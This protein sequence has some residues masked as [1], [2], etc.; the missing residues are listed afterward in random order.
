MSIIKLKHFLN[1]GT[2]EIQLIAT[3]NPPTALS[4]GYSAPFG[5]HH[6]SS[7][8]NSVGNLSGPEH[9]LSKSGSLR[10]QLQHSIHFAVLWKYCQRPLPATTSPLENRCLECHQ[11]G[12]R[13]P[14]VFSAVLITQKGDCSRFGR[15]LESLST[16]IQGGQSSL[17]QESQ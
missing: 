14:S 8:E 12:R 11:S 6:P 17:V 13:S 7:I 5:S 1:N 3:R 2:L 4:L 16:F 10:A 9:L 15:L